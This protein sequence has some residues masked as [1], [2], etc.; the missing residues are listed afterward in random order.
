M[1]R[2][3]L[4]RFWEVLWE[5]GEIFIRISA[6]ELAAAFGYYAFFSI[7]PFLAMLLWAGSLFFNPDTVA[8]TVKEYFPMSGNV[9]QLVWEGVHALQSTH[10][11]VNIAF[12]LVFLWASLRFFQILVHG[13]NLAWCEGDLPWWQ[14]PLKNLIMVLTVVSALLLGIVAPMLLQ[15]VRNIVLSM[16]ENMQDILDIHFPDWD[17]WPFLDLIDWTRF[18]LASTVLFYAFSVLYMLAPSVRVHFRKVWL[19]ALAVS[20]LLQGMQVLFV[21][22]LPMFLKYNAIYG[23]M[24]G[25]MFLLMWI[26]LSGLVILAGACWC[27]ARERIKR[28]YAALSDAC[29]QTKDAAPDFCI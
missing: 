26:Y 1:L 15:V 8:Q 21:N 23:T 28:K 18:L 7:F 4:W 24:G 13:V 27:S 11:T 9:S 14:L 25:V 17:I 12:I 16:Q 29:T 20:F 2:R 19:Q 3:S 5:A 6:Y 10:G 22:Y